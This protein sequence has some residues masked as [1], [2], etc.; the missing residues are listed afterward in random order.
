LKVNFSFESYSLQCF[1]CFAVHRRDLP[2]G[3]YRRH[4]GRGR[5][6]QESTSTNVQPNHIKSTIIVPSP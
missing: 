2:R 5:P 4:S 3:L 1:Q 6:S